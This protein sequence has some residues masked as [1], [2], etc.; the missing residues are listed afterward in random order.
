MIKFP[1]TPG[2][3]RIVTGTNALL[4][5]EIAGFYCVGSA[6]VKGTLIKTSANR[7]TH[8]LTA[9]G[10][11]TGGML[12]FSDRALVMLPLSSITVTGTVIAF[13]G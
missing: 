7:N 2:G 4:S 13:V 12:S 1:E 8:E 9:N 5:K 11:P 3:I 10:T 6:S